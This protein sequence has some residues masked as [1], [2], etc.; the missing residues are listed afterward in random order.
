MLA[1][2]PTIGLDIR[3]WLGGRA[4]D[5]DELWALNERS[6]RKVRWGHS[7]HLFSACLFCALLAG[8]KSFLEVS[9]A[10]LLITAFFRL[11]ATWRL[12][13]SL[14]RQPVSILTA[15]VLFYF[16]IGILWSPNRARGLEEFDVARWTMIVPALWPVRHIR[17]HLILLVALSFLSAH[18]AQLVQALAFEFGWE[19]FDFDAFSTR[20]SGWLHHASGASVLVGG[21]GLHLPAALSHTHKLRW[22]ARVLALI[23]LLGVFATG[24][25]AAWIGAALVILVALAL[26]LWASHHR[27]R[28]LLGVLVAGALFL[29][30]GWLTLGDEIKSRY[31]EGKE[32]ITL[33]IEQERFT[34]STGARINMF[35]W[36]REAFV[37]HPMLGVGPGGFRTWAVETQ[38]ERGMDPAKHPVYDD[39]HSSPAQ[40][41][42]T[43]GLVGLALYIPLVIAL[44]LVSKPRPGEEQ[45]YQA[46]LMMA[47]LGV[48]L[49]SGL[50]AIH[51]KTDTMAALWTF[52]A[53]SMRPSNPY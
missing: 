24:S 43:Q 49:C 50:D 38:L 37:Q 48:L 11:Y 42:A 18:V 19:S 6:N 26:A 39:A 40:I 5:H 17:R 51:L 31:L 32:E 4:I 7:I 20:I 52:V 28:L 53:L 3:S 12:Y 21:L 46:G 29:V 10:I 8:P 2:M 47:I 16:A 9:A 33:A 25:R 23:T 1:A 36:A 30:G 15:V 13:P 34:T 44:V 45:T 27:V 35:I 41:G 22:P 14:L